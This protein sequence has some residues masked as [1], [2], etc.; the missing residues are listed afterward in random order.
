MKDLDLH[1]LSIFDAVM[2]EGSVTKAADRLAMTQSAVS[3]AIARMRVVWDDPLFTR[4]GRGIKAS[5][6]AQELWRE[7][8][9]PLAAIRMAAS[10][11]R[12]EAA[13]STR[14]FR[15]AVTDYLSGALWPVLRQH[16]EQHAPH[17]RILAVPYTSQAT[18]ARLRDNEIDLCL[19]GLQHL[20]DEF[21]LQ[22]L[23]TENW[24]CAMRRD[25]PLAKSRITEAR[26]LTAEH[27][28]VSLSGDP[29]GVADAALERAGKRR[30]VAMTLNNFA[31]APALLL[32]SNLIAVLPEGVLLTH[33]LKNQVHTCEV[34]LEIAPFD[35]QMA[36][37]T[38]NT[39]DAAHRWIRALIAG[40]CD[41]IWNAAGAS[42]SG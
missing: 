13:T 4:H 23:F 18:S 38:R 2:T 36:W 32:S 26:F 34:P 12:F 41:R 16:I 30:R 22:R 27:L 37:H 9:E 11:V 6:R 25:H 21:K 31:G 35:C 10:P 40:T 1:L 28:L 24:V 3:N 29:V 20:G 5:A 7:I 17:I 19:G 14:A 42:R 15:I 8:Q 39:R 33:P